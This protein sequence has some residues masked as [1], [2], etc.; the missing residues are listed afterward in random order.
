[1]SCNPFVYYKVIVL[2]TR[3]SSAGTD[4]FRFVDNCQD[5]LAAKS[6]VIGPL[7]KI[8]NKSDKFGQHQRS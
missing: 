4:G 6:E 3:A 1:M 7:I 2:I 5:L 8:I